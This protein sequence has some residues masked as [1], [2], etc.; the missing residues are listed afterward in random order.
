MVFFAWAFMVLISYFQQLL[1]GFLQFA[2]DS[3]EVFAPGCP[4]LVENFAQAAGVSPELGEEFPHPDEGFLLLDGD[5]LLP[6]EGD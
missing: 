5:F 1:G 4:L 6:D 2:G 3:L